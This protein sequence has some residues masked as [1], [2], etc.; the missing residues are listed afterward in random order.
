MTSPIVLCYHALSPTWEASLSTTPERFER[1]IEMLVRRGYRG[2]TFSEAVSSAPGDRVL[3]VTFDDAYRSV[4]EI[5]RP[6]LD[7]FRLT[8][9]VFAPSDQI[10]RQGPL[11]WEGI[12]RWLGGPHESELWPMSWDEL[13]ILAADGWE[14]G[15]HTATHPHLT[16]VEDSV[17]ENE[18]TRSKA[19]CEQELGTPCTSVAYPYGD[20]DDRVV[21][22]AVRAG[23]AAGAA[24][25]GRL[26]AEH[27]MRWP[28]IGVYYADDDRRFRLK[29]S[30][31]VRRLRAS[32]AWELLDS[33]RR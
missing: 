2:A 30:P 4:I 33:L 6:I 31:A 13:R 14:I 27:P 9:T 19:V 16:R 23:Y 8:A 10:G 5:A 22:G 29:V 11:R 12:D 18:L 25:P 7:R 17:L 1:Q 26:H 3:A 28:R 20:V 32:P 21:A 24:L 15:S